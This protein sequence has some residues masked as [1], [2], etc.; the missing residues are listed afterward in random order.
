MKNLLLTTIFILNILLPKNAI[1]TIYL[2]TNTNDSGIGSL[3]QALINA[4][5]NPGADS[6]NF[7]I[8]GTNWVITLLTSLPSI[9]DSL[10]INGFS[11]PGSSFNSSMITI[12]PNLTTTTYAIFLHSN[13]IKITGLNFSNFSTGA[14]IY[15]NN[16]YIASIF[17][18]ISITW[19]R[20]NNS[21]LGINITYFGFHYF[22]IAMNSFTNCAYSINLNPSSQSSYF[23]ISGN[24]IHGDTSAIF[25][26]GISFGFQSSPS[27]RIYNLSIS[28]NSISHCCTGIILENYAKL[29]SVFINSNS[30]NQINGP[31]IQFNSGQSTNDSC[32]NL[33]VQNNVCPDGTGIFIRNYSFGNSTVFTNLSILNNTL[34]GKLGIEIDG[35]GTYTG[36]IKNVLIQGNYCQ[37]GIDFLLSGTGNVIGKM[38]NIVVLNNTIISEP[39]SILLRGTGYY[40]GL[41]KNMRIEN[42]QCLSGILCDL[43]FTGSYIGQV[44]SISI[45][46][47]TISNQTSHGIIFSEWGSS[48]TRAYISN[49][50]LHKN[51]IVGCNGNGIQ[52]EN[53]VNCN[54]RGYIYN[55][56]ID[57][58]QIQNSLYNGILLNL[59]D[60]SLGKYFYNVTIEDN[61]ISN[62][63][64]NG[65]SIET[66]YSHPFTNIE[67]LRNSIFNNDSIGIYETPTSVYANPKLP[68]PVLTCADSTT[69]YIWG[70]LQSK[71]NTIYNIQF[72]ENSAPGNNGKGEG[73]HYFLTHRITTDSTGYAW[74]QINIPSGITGPYFTCTATDTLYKSTSEFSNE[75]NSCPTLSITT[76]KGNDI[77][78]SPVPA[79]NFVHLEFDHQVTC[80]LITIT[81][82]S[83]R[84]VTRI[85]PEGTFST[86]EIDV[87]SLPNGYYL[88]NILNESGSASKKLIIQH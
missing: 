64:R 36:W 57:S 2:V 7:Q 49:I 48:T 41:L 47:N 11:Q 73:E 51:S 53:N 81:D 84:T 26:R 88:V 39:I 12:Q 14:C 77:T 33:V 67:I 6:I 61:I 75:I 8:S 86:I 74:F 70:Y 54:A 78:L 63:S 4:N 28:G 19:N 66:N 23:S 20:F 22:E 16:Q 83:G 80:D 65:I 85:Y 46:G 72:Y 13:N 52:F 18:D 60:T 30:F 56:K 59:S 1:G 35:N 27:Y 40:N 43:R 9:N 21:N 5:N 15:T 37:N 58:N 71:A 50:N 44:D 32:K 76:L 82:L 31:S 25:P 55:I 24:E 17:Q 79:S 45:I 10:S 87:S 69:A 3:R 62:N 34:Q 68:E 29:D 42:N 38:D